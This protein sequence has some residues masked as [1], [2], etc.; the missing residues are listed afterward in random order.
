M[1]RRIDFRAGHPFAKLPT[2]ERKSIQEFGSQKVGSSRITELKMLLLENG[3]PVEINL[4]SDARQQFP[5]ISSDSA[6][7][8]LLQLLNF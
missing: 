8:E 6:T 1:Q 7:P 5:A 3:I 2:R 4:G